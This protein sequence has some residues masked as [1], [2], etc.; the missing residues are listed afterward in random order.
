V[1]LIAFYLPQFHPIPE[2]DA[3]WGEGFTEWTN[4]RPAQPLY[5]G[6]YQ[7]H[8]PGDLGYYD[9]LDGQ[10][11]RR[12]VELAKQYGLGGFCFYFYWF[13]GKRLLETPVERYLADASL[14]L[15]FCLCWANENWSRR[16]DGLD[17]EILIGQDHSPEDDLAFI[18]HIAQYMRD[19]RYIRID[20]KPLLLVY[21]P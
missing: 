5:E 18:A 3:W 13:G 16:W 8:V 9:L 4:V 21:R 11:Q 1:R 15:P 7:P 12:Q 14:D 2:N 6:H 20:G 17:H 19:S 10:T